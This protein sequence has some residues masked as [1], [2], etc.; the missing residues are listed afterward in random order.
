MCDAQT[1]KPVYGE[2]LIL[3]GA[4]ILALR[5]ARLLLPRKAI[6]REFHIAMA[7]AHSRRVPLSLTPAAKKA[8]ARQQMLMYGSHRA[9]Y[10]ASF[11]TSHCE[12]C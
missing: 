1:V 12:R 9:R 7:E 5:G 8:D 3:E 2:H 10:A 6:L 4:A 11:M